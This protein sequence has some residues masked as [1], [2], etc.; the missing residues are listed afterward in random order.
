M[1]SLNFSTMFH[2]ILWNVSERLIQS[3]PKWW[4]NLENKI[5]VENNKSTNNQLFSKELINI[6]PGNHTHFKIKLKIAFLFR[7]QCFFPSVC[8]LI[9]PPAQ[10]KLDKINVL[11]SF[12]LMFQKVSS[13]HH[14]CFHC[15]SGFFFFPLSFKRDP[16]PS[17]ALCLN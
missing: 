5:R 13:L 8:R 2:C 11:L 6:V 9:D 3:G 16:G 10:Q 4:T 17:K 15:D 12:H 7:H 1:S 14:N